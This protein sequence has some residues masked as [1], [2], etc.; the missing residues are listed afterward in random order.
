M[1]MME[2]RIKRTT[3]VARMRRKMHTLSASIPEG[4]R[5]LF[6]M[7]LHRTLQRMAC[8]REMK[9]VKVAVNKNPTKL[10]TGA[11]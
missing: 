3:H 7:T 2:C 9:G 5:A 6:W 11:Q 10:T 8:W 1:K 4:K